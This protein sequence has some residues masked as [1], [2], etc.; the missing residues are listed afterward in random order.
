MSVEYRAEFF[1]ETVARY[2]VPCNRRRTLNIVGSACGNIV[3]YQFFSNTAAEENYDLLLHVGL[4]Y[5]G[6]VL[7]RNVHC[8]AARHSARNDGHLMYLILRLAEV[9][10]D[11]VAGFVIS[12]ELLLLRSYDLGLLLRTCNHLDSSFL[13]VRLGYRAAVSTRSKQSRLVYKVLEVCTGKACG[14][15]RDGTTSSYEGL[16]NIMEALEKAKVRL[17]ANVNFDITMEML[18]LT[19]KEN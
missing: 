8:E 10:R 18:L 12:C 13:D 4:A 9:G 14:C 7:L 3:K 1:G 11:S 6:S 19:I 17:N 15:C 16:N 5:E 2:H